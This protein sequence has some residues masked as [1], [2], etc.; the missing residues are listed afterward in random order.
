MNVGR[1]IFYDKVTGEKIVDTGE[2][3]NARIKKTVDEQI[4]TFKELSERN[5]ETFDVLELAFGERAQDFAE[6]NGYHVNVETKTLEFSYP[7]PNEPPTEPVYQK[8]LSIELEETKQ[9]IAELTLLV[10]MGGM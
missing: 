2:W 6:C 3:E 1:M 9:A 5:R 4:D 7:D 8:P 10:S